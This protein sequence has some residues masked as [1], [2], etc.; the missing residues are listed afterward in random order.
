MFVYN[1]SINKRL[2]F[3]IR[4]AK[5]WAHLIAE[6]FKIFI[7]I[8]IINY[9]N[10]NLITKLIMQKPSSSNPFYFFSLFRTA[11]RPNWTKNGLRKSKLEF[12]QEKWNW[13]KI[14]N[15]I[16]SLRKSKEIKNRVHVSVSIRASHS[17]AFAPCEAR[18]KPFK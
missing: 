12:T 9:K 1:L 3:L 14:E 11:W 8:F 15:L 17:W 4:V 13:K 2:Y 5:I 16:F 18:L 7:K 6:K 10:L